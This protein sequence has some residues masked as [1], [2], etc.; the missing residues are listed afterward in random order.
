M[1]V[2]YIDDEAGARNHFLNAHATDGI[3]V[4]SCSDSLKVHEMLSNRL[5][6]DLPDLIVLDLYRTNGELDSAEAQE[7]NDRVDRIVEKIAKNREQLEVLVKAEKEPAAIRALEALKQEPSMKEIPV[8]ISTREGL[9]LLDDEL[10]KK[11]IDL[12]AD[13]MIKG[14]SPEVIR[15][16]MYRNFQAAKIARKRVKRD[17]WLTL[18]GALLGA[19]MSAFITWIAF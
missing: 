19:L 11:S 8:I 3:S 7:V 18:S 14:K 9:N 12:G 17:V 15:A 6:K 4:E 1:K 5:K 2:L 16:L 13:W 10:L